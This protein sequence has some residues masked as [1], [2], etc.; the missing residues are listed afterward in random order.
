M[1][2]YSPMTASSVKKAI[3]EIERRIIRNTAVTASRTIK[4]VPIGP[5]NLPTRTSI[6]ETDD[7]PV[8]IKVFVID[9]LRISDGTT[10]DIGISVNIL[11]YVSIFSGKQRE[12][13]RKPTAAGLNISQP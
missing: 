10:D 7:V 3:A 8:R 9:W 2:A 12:A 11:G 5:V 6:S 4:P 13:N 1:N